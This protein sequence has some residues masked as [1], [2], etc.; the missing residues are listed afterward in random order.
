MAGHLYEWAAIE[1]MLDHCAPGWTDKIVD[2][3]RVLYFGSMTF[4]IPLG[5][6]RDRGQRSCKAE[7]QRGKVN[8]LIRAFKIIECAKT[9]LD[10]ITIS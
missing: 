3:R 6:H 2:H 10:G 7:I 9:V 8:C 1:E 4:T 5:E